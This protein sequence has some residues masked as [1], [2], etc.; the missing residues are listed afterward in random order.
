MDINNVQNHVNHGL[1]A[2][3]IAPNKPNQ[4]NTGF[5]LRTADGLTG[6][7]ISI[8]FGF[9][10]LKETSN[11]SPL[12][13]FERWRATNPYTDKPIPKPIQNPS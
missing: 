1:K 6:V 8:L 10:T 3:V 2:P 5:K 9:K 4:T 7:L 13:W 12:R 11:L